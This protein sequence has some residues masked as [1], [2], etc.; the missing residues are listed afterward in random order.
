MLRG[1]KRYRLSFNRA[2]AGSSRVA[3]CSSMQQVY[4]KLFLSPCQQGLPA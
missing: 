4:V 3:T 2:E 1:M